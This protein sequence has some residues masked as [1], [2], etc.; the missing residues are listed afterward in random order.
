MKLK[1]FNRSNIKSPV[2]NRNKRATVSVNGKT[3]LIGFSKRAAQAMELKPGSGVVFFQD[4]ESGADWFVKC[5][6]D[7]EAIVL[8]ENDSSSMFLFNSSVLA[9]SILNA[10]QCRERYVF[11]V[12]P[13]QEKA[14]KIEGEDGYHLIIT[15]KPV[16]ARAW[17]E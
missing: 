12:F 4:E 11:C 1:A 8:R 15:A 6:E 5:S 10:A 3:G 17:K 14:M 7:A 2:G 16:R 9:Q 13:I